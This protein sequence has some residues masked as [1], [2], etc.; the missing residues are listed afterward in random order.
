M[1]FLKAKSV[2]SIIGA[3]KKTIAEL[4]E[5]SAYHAAQ[6]DQQMEQANALRDRAEASEDESRRAAEIAKKLQGIVG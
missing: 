6:H 2:D 5:A 3:F 4:Q 1:A